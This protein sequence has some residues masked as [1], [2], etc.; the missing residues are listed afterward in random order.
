MSRGE[1]SLAS[2]VFIGL[3]NR[4]LDIKSTNTVK[5]WT[6]ES[7]LWGMSDRDVATKPTWMYSWRPRKKLPGGRAVED[8]HCKMTELLS[9]F[10]SVKR[11]IGGAEQCLEVGKGVQSAL[12]SFVFG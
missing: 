2:N 5:A 6:P 4:G 10:F 9:C 8:T 1:S 7:L 3:R 11:L 12:V